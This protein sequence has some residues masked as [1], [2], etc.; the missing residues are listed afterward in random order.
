[1]IAP[2]NNSTLIQ[3][4][5]K[6]HWPT[7]TMIEVDYISTNVDPVKYHDGPRLRDEYPP[8]V[9]WRIGNRRYSYVLKPEFIKNHWSA[10]I[11]SGHDTTPDYSKDQSTLFKCLQ[12]S[13]EGKDA[14]EINMLLGNHN[15][16]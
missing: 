6:N 12:W 1:M 4:M 14:S 10:L 15:E 3:Q 7:I 8:V 11:F 2:Y 9:R 16:Q 13:V 5:I